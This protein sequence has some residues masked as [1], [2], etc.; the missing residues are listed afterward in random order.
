MCFFPSSVK[1]LHR[2][3]PYENVS[4]K[5]HLA[6]V[7]PKL[8]IGTDMEPTPP[9]DGIF[10]GGVWPLQTLSCQSCATQAISIIP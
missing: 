10:Q 5:Y 6:D 7:F 2:L 9:S 1:T 4:S 8:F 3:D